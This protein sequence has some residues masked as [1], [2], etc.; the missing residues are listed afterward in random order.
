M[1]KDIR[2]ISKRVSVKDKQG[3]AGLVIANPFAFVIDMRSSINFTFNHFGTLLLLSFL[4]FYHQA[5]SLN[6]QSVRL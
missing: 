3:D 4:T 2:V 1:L 6:K 5:A